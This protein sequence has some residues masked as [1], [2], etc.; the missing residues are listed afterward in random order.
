[1]GKITLRRALDEYKNVYMAYRNFA[2]RT[3]EEYQN[4]VKDFIKFS[5]KSGTVTTGGVGLPIIERFVANL[6]QKGF[7]SLTRKRKV[8]SI[9]SFLLFLFQDG[10]I[11]TNIASRVV[12][13]FIESSMPNVLTQTECDRIRNACAENPRD[14]A[15]IEL[16]LQTGIKLS[17]LVHLTK[18]DI[19]FEGIMEKGK[20]YN[21]YIRILGGRKK[22]DRMIP[23][24]T[25]ACLALR[26]YLDSRK[27]VENNVLFLNKF[28]QA[29]GERGVQ[30]MFRKHL[31]KTG[32]VKTSIHTLRHTFG[33]QQI[34]KG[35]SPQNI[36]R[37]M[38]LRDPRST[39]MYVSLVRS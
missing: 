7:A 38:G 12:L 30:K 17:E 34:A 36:Q 19:E 37:V 18:T 3:R 9:R 32:I 25:K 1:M 13:P 11:D 23:L 35:I 22:R 33:A 2:E 21:G 20:K 29:M 27:G 8:V 10:Y 31:K 39:S 14:A 26:N 28:S 15:I 24:N 6:E 16:L 5:E 4:D